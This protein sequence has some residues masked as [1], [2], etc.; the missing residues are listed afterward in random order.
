[1][2]K[3]KGSVNALTVTKKVRKVKEEIVGVFPPPVFSSQIPPPPIAWTI[4]GTVG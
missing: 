3:E 1:M 2:V 4:S